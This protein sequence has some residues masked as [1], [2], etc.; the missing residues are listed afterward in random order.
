[1]RRSDSTSEFPRIKT[2][3]LVVEWQPVEQFLERLPQIDRVAAEGNGGVES[4]R[5]ISEMASQTEFPR[6]A[7]FGVGVRYSFT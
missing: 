5:G 7:T 2:T 3:K 6:W 4:T 1:M